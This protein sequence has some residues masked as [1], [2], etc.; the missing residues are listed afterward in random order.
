M[1]VGCDCFRHNLE[2][3]FAGFESRRDGMTGCEMMGTGSDLT[4]A[5]G[6]GCSYV[7][8]LCR[9]CSGG[10]A[11]SVELEEPLEDDDSDG[12]IDGGEGYADC[13]AGR[14]WGVVGGVRSLAGDWWWYFAAWSVARR[15][16]K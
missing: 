1:G 6:T 12:I 11:N 16:R 9:C 13:G 3:K 5:R 15:C 7:Y 10:E 4:I 2:N 8:E 14:R